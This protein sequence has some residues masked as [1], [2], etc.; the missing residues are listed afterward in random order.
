MIIRVE[1]PD[2]SCV[3]RNGHPVTSAMKVW[4]MA[5]HAVINFEN[6]RGQILNAGARID[7][8]AMDEFARQWCQQRAISLKEVP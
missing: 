1:T 3:S 6:R 4:T 2:G 5:D 8:T 7:I